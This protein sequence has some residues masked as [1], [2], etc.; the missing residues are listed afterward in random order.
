MCCACTD[1]YDYSG[2]QG[3]LSGNVA[4]AGGSVHVGPRVAGS[5]GGVEG[6]RQASGGC[7]SGCPFRMA[8]LVRSAGGPGWGS[9]EG[10]A[11]RWPTGGDVKTYRYIDIHSKKKKKIRGRG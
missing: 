7:P 1:N 2:Y 3:V 4:S 5:P 6:W 10:R 11:R 8:G 9:T